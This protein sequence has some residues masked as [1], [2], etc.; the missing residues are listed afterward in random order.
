M[1]LRIIKDNIAEIETGTNT[2]ED[3]IRIYD[4]IEY[5]AGRLKEQYEQIRE[6]EAQGPE[7]ESRNQLIQALNHLEE[8]DQCK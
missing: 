5:A 4:R 3:L 1:D 8:P 2:V 6:D 7:L